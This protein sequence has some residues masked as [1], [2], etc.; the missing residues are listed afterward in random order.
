MLYFKSLLAGIAAMI[1]AEFIVIAGAITLLFGI[2]WDPSVL[3]QHRGWLNYSCACFRRWIFVA[4]P[5]TCCSRTDFSKASRQEL[6]ASGSEC[7]SSQFS[8]TAQ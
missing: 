8:L 2:G 4:I 1:V 6:E 7:Y 3:H 5:E